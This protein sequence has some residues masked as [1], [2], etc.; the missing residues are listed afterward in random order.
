[1]PGGL[2]GMAGMGGVEPSA[3]EAES[4][5][6]STM[7]EDEAR[8][9]VAKAAAQGKISTDQ[10]QK[11]LESTPGAESSSASAPAGG[12]SEKKSSGF[13]KLFKKFK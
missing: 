11:L 13:A 9:L 4:S 6:A 8:A 12:P 1:M 5:P 7:T 2:P 10:A 3:I